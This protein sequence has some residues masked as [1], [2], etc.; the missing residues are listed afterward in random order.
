MAARHVGSEL[1]S[2][3]AN[4]HWKVKFSLLNHQGSASVFTFECK[5]QVLGLGHKER[6]AT[7]TDTLASVV[8]MSPGLGGES[9]DGLSCDICT[10]WG[11]HEQKATQTPRQSPQWPKPPVPQKRQT[12]QITV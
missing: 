5:A 4:L 12:E 8:E 3:G 1:P 11:I 10:V 9:W 2:Q 7:Q 6:V